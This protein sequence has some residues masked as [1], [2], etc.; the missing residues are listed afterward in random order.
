MNADIDTVK[1]KHILYIDDVGTESTAV[2]YGERRLAFCE[3]VDED[4]K[5][6]KLLMLTTNLS[7]E[8]I[9]QKYGERTMERLGAINRSVKVEG[10]SLRR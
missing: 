9:Y 5:R 3:I 4:E 2:K 10:K 8:E 1:Q 7:L 6:G